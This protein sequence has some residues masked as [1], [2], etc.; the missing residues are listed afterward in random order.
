[1][2]EKKNIKI[3]RGKKAFDILELIRIHPERYISNKN[4]NALQDFL[5]GY[6]AGNPYPDDNPP[7]WNFDHFLLEQTNFDIKNG[8]QNL[9][10]KILLAESH[11]DGNKAFDIFFDY[12][13]EYKKTGNNAG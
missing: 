2:E 7:F 1:M 10:S 13:A 6:L 5:N 9:I 4:I 11:G 8:N 12:L 3:Y